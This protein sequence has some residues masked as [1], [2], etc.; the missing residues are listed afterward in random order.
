MTVPSAWSTWHLA[1][2]LEAVSSFDTEASAALGAVERAAE[3]LDAEVAAILSAGRVVAS[4]GYPAGGVPLA[5]LRAAGYSARRELPIP[6]QGQCPAV[7]VSLDHPED[8]RLVV[9]R[10]GTAAFAREEVS[11]LRGM[12]RVTSMTMRMLRLL[13]DERTARRELQVLATELAASRARAVAAADATRQRIGRDLHDGVQ[14]HLAS[15]ALTVRLAEG[16]TPPESPELRSCLAQVATGLQDVFR[17]LQEMARGLHPTLLSKAGLGPVLRMVSNRS[18]VPVDL[19]L[20][21]ETRLPAAVETAAYYIVSE[22]LA[23]A[24]KHAGASAVR[25]GVRLADGMLRID[26]CD[27][28]IGGADTTHGSGLVGLRDRV[29]ALGGTITVSSPRGG[30]TAIAAELPV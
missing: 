17:E 14:Q 5:E 4:V 18:A 9:A 3:A 25:V 23:N 30:G 21:L 12:A 19:D 27:D 8:A 11:I 15:L 2:F 10:S 26:V 1:E 16:L 7:A 29:A 24:V 6:G 22:G 20:D 28:G 13:D